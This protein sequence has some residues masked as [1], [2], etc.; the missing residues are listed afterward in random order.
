MYIMLFMKHKILST[1]L[2]ELHWK[3]QTDIYGTFHK[4]CLNDHLKNSLDFN[5][6]AFT[7]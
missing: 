1:R 7:S 2:D 5:E 6:I 4:H 3:K